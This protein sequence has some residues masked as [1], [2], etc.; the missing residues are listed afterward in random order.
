MLGLLAAPLVETLY[1]SQWRDAAPLIQI[2]CIGMIPYVLTYIAADALTGLGKISAV[3]HITLIMALV[4]II[5][6]L[7]SAPFGLVAVAAT[8]QAGSLIRLALV[9]HQIT[10]HIGVRLKDMAHLIVSNLLVT[11]VTSLPAAVGIALYGW[12]LDY[13]I[14]RLLL[15]I[16]TSFLFWLAAIYAIKPP[17]YLEIFPAIRWLARQLPARR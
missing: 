3:F 5:L 16:T 7:L 6:I 15:V 8:M 1:G 14:T 11:L 4:N 9:N 12:T 13:S 2:M 17:L 10:Q